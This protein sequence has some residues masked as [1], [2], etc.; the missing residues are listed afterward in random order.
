[1]VIEH[2]FVT[3]LEAPEALEV[4]RRVLTRCGFLP[5]EQDESTRD[6]RAE[7]Q[8]G[9]KR[10]G[11]AKSISQLPQR[12]LVD[13][14][15][16]RVSLALSIEPSPTWGGG[17][18]FSLSTSGKPSKM[19]LHTELLMA[20]ATGLDRVLAGGVDEEQAMEPWR[21]VEARIAEAARRRRRRNLW[22]VFG[23]AAAF[24]GMIVL[25]VVLNTR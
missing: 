2:D 9:L 24:V 21:H 19:I 18:S 20:M 25:I 3:T 6:T 22:V 8:R 12:A 10:A 13:Y 7:F 16:G 4:A 14:D 17:G 23:F 1:M 15:R 11:G 5:L